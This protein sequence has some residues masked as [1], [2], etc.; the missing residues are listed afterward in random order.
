M[1]VDPTALK[2][3][4]QTDPTG[5]GYGPWVANGADATLADLL[6]EPR[7]GITV[8]RGLIDTWELIAA[9]VRSEY[10][11]LLPDGK[12]LYQTLVSAGTLDVTDASI[13]ALLAGLFPAGSS[14]RANLIAR[15]SRR[16]SRAE[17]L[18]GSGVRL[19][20]EAVGFALRETA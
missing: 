20:H 13:R 19:S 15:V 16:G 18:F 3:E 8:F 7:A 11:A 4:L 14:T 12:Q 6:N 10:D 2:T 5:L 9:T 17:Q 1:A